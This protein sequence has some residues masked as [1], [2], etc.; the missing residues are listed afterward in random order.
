MIR[1]VP[2]WSVW[3]I[4]RIVNF[5]AVF[6]WLLMGCATTKN[7]DS[8]QLSPPVPLVLK[9]LS[10]VMSELKTSPY[11]MEGNVKNIRAKDLVGLSRKEIVAALG[12]EGSKCDEANGGWCQRVGDVF[13]SFYTMCENC[14]GGGPEL[15]LRF[16]RSGICTW[17]KW[18]I[19][20]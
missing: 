14:L 16:N 15:A 10:A 11:A 17:A 4:S 5:C 6:A 7:D 13:F 3:S 18:F 12:S 2:W 9:D 8:Q 1:A 20:E 19:S